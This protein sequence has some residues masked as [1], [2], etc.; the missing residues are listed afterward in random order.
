MYWVSRVGYSQSIWLVKIF[1][2]C[3]KLNKYL[4]LQGYKTMK[5]RCGK[6]TFLKH[7]DK[8]KCSRRLKRTVF[9]TKKGRRE[10][11]GQIFRNIKKCTERK[12]MHRKEGHLKWYLK[13][14][15]N[16]LGDK[17]QCHCN[18]R[19]VTVIC[20]WLNFWQSRNKCWF[21]PWMLEIS[22]HQ[23]T[24]ALKSFF[25][26]VDCSMAREIGSKAA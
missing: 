8:M 18:S 11:N 20:T 10:W 3:L 6:S 22:V 26:T 9:V 25:S 13:S 14:E 5:F 12:K 16:S 1:Q 24:S 7:K 21:W 23:F 19:H 2:T 4:K 15:Y 17:I